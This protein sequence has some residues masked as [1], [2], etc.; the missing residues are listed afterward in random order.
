MRLR[1]S[2]VR[3]GVPWDVAWCLP[4]ADA[5]AYCVVFGELDG[6]AFDWSAMAWK[7][8]KTP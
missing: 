4:D 3:C 2:L 1:L 5:L 8:R 6:G 7:K